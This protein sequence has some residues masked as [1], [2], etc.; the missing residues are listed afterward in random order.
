MVTLYPNIKILISRFRDSLSMKENNLLKKH[1]PNDVPEYISGYRLINVIDP[2]KPFN[3]Y[4]FANYKN[5]AGKK[6]FAKIWNGKIKNSAF[7]W[8]KNE[9]HFYEIISKINIMPDRKHISI[10]KLIDTYQEKN[11]L[12]MF[13]ESIQHITVRPNNSQLTKLYDEVIDYIQIISKKLTSH[14]KNI[15]L[16]IGPFEIFIGSLILSIRAVFLRPELWKEI[17]KINLY[18]I[19]HIE[20]INNQKW[21]Q[22][23]HR[24]LRGSVLMNG[25]NKYIIDWQTVAISHPLLELAQLTLTHTENGKFPS[26][27]AELNIYQRMLKTNNLPIYKCLCN[28]VALVELALVNIKEIT[29]T[30][31]FLNSI[32]KI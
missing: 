24:D 1:S 8:L 29:D 10:P 32:S 12:I 7:Y 5:K 28:Y 4:R 11:R 16:H 27:L 26:Y 17:V 31:I 20:L 13:I 6:V 21:D 22:L 18:L 14:N 23:V 2:N 3:M 19:K 9:I 25:N 15:F 30:K